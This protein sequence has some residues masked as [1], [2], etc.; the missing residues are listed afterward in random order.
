MRICSLGM[1]TEHKRMIL[2]QFFAIIFFAL[3]LF[4]LNGNEFLR[5]SPS[6]TFSSL[7]DKLLF[8]I[9][10]IILW[11]AINHSIIFMLQN[12]RFL[13]PKVSTYFLVISFLFSFTLAAS[14]EMHLRSFIDKFYYFL[15][16]GHLYPNFIDLRGFI[17]GINKVEYVGEAFSVKCDEVDLP[18][19][20]WGWSYGSTILN[21]RNIEFIN[22]KNTF[23]FALIIFIVLLSTVIFLAQDVLT[24][25]IYL[26]LS[27]TGVSLIIVERMNIDVL[28]LLV[29]VWIVKSKSKFSKLLAFLSLILFSLTKFYTFALIPLVIFFEKS[30][31]LRLIYGLLLLVAAPIALKDLSVSGSGS[32]NF[33]YAAT[34]GMKNL[35][36]SITNARYPTLVVSPIEG[37]L[38]SFY[39]TIVFFYFFK[40]YWKVLSIQKLDFDSFEIRLFVLCSINLIFAWLIASNY[41]YRL[42]T[43]LGTIPFLVKIFKN[44]PYL[45]ALNIGLCFISMALLPI[46]LSILRN[47]YFSAVIVSFFVLNLILL[48]KYKNFGIRLHNLL[49]RF[50]N[51]GHAKGI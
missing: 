39:L 42:V 51:F 10:A 18:C 38:I 17:A 34:F 37:L 4:V 8:N 14:Y 33:G 5:S 41:P 12:K 46:T 21:L 11:I 2:T 24:R 27:V 47:L 35:F 44:N 40:K 23:I 22:E 29:L 30:V 48:L 6:S 1:Y 28:V 45:F 49:A 50:F 20:G 16:I 36:G 26:L 15:G 9:S 43:I 31:K 32:L 7:E 25:N 19:I 3:V 13:G